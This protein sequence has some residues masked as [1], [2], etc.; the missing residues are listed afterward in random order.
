MVFTNA[1]VATRNVG[2]HRFIA[3]KMPIQTTHRGKVACD[4][5]KAS[6]LTLYISCGAFFR[7]ARYSFIF[8]QMRCTEEVNKLWDGHTLCNRNNASCKSIKCRLDTIPRKDLILEL[9]GMA[10]VVSAWSSKENC[11]CCILLQYLNSWSNCSKS[12]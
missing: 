7:T 1:S 11:C 2:R 3:W 5:E 10:S 4:H 6:S 9:I 12:R 8:P